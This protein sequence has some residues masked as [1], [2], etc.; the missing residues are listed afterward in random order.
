MLLLPELMEPLTFKNYKDSHT[1]TEMQFTVEINCEIY[2]IRHST[3]L[4]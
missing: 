2:I 4:L 1:W 3:V